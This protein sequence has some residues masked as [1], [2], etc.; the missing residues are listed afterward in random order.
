[1]STTDTDGS[2]GDRPERQRPAA[3]SRRWLHARA[4]LL[5]S[6]GGPGL[7]VGFVG[8]AVVAL[9][10]GDPVGAADAVFA[11]GTLVL[12]FALLGWSGSAMLG[13]RGEDAV[14]H[15]GIS[16]DWTERRS[17]RAM[18]RLAGLGAGVMVGATAVGVPF[19]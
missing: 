10:G 19:Y 5:W 4:V 1:M 3:F 15:L 9:V 2:R 16:G 12:G 11:V 7:G 8:A 17:R 13:G 14:R 6:G 18:T